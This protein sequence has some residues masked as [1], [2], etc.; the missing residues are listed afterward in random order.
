MLFASSHTLQL[1]YFNPLSHISC[2][3]CNCRNGRQYT[4]NKMTNTTTERYNSE[5]RINGQLK[6]T[7]IKGAQGIGNVK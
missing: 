3:V 4:I 7:I 5:L 2:D 6:D 1:H